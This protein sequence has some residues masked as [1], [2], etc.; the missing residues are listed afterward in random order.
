M[1]PELKEDNGYSK[2]F[3]I[4]GDYTSNEIQS[5]ARIE[6]AMGAILLA[7]KSKTER[8]DQ[9]RDARNILAAL[10]IE[11]RNSTIET[12]VELLNRE[13]RKVRILQI[14][15]VE[16]IVVGDEYLGNLIAHSTR[17]NGLARALSELLTSNKG[18]EFKKKRI[19]PE[20]SEHL[21]GKR[22]VDALLFYKEKYD[23]LVFAV[24]TYVDPADQEALGID[25]P[26]DLVS[27]YYVTNPP[28]DYVIK[29]DDSF[30]VIEK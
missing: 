28:P 17:A 24:E 7:D 6:Y 14:A 16:N 23:A 13:P 10:T 12:C 21:I 8:S 26:K 18:N 1:P 25:N 2:I 19:L 22:Y 4:T 11:K 20:D 29:Q 3:Y 5:E 15:N 30:F 27:P 9:D